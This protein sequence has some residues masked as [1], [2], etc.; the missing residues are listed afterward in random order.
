MFLVKE[1]NVPVHLFN[2]A[3][4]Q[5]AFQTSPDAALV[6]RAADGA[7]LHVNDG[8]CR[9]TG[10]TREEVIGKT[11]LELNLYNHPAD[12][13]QFLSS[14]AKTGV[15][16]SRAANFRRRDGNRFSALVSAKTFFSQ[17]EA[18]VYASLRDLSEQQ[19][20][21]HKKS[22]HEE[23]FRRLFETMSQ[24]VVY[25]DADGRIVS[26]NPAAQ[27]MLGL[28]LAELTQRTS[29]APEWKTIREDGSIL[30]GTEHPSMIALRTGAPYG[31]YTL[32]VYNEKI[33]D[34]VWLSVTATPLFHGEETTPYQAYVVMSDITAQRKAQQN[35][36]QLFQEVMDGFALHEIIIDVAG[37][38]VDYR[39]LAVNPAFERMTGLSGSDLI[40]RTVLEVLPETEQYWIETYGK[41]ALTGEPVTFQNYAASL[42]KYFSV[43]AYRPAPM[44][45]ACTFSDVTGQIRYQQETE[46]AQEQ[47]NRLAHICDVAPSAILVHDDV[48]KILYANEYAYRM[49]GYPKSVFLTLLLSDLCETATS[50]AIVKSAQRARAEGE[51]TNEIVS[52]A[53]D[54]RA[55]P[56]LIYGRPIEWDGE[57]AML[58]I[59]TDI[60]ERQRAEKTLEQSLAQN[61]R[62]LNNLQDG[63]FQAALS[64]TFYMLNPRMAQIYGYDSVAEMMT[65]NT[66]QM[67]ANLEDRAAL[68]DKLQT[69]GQVTSYVCRG[70]RKN[71][72]L[73]WVSMHVQYLRDEA[74]NVIGT[75][76]LIRDITDRRMMEEEIQKQHNSLLAS[77][78]ILKKQLEQSIQAI[79]KIGELR[80]AYTAGHQKRVQQLACQIGARCGLSGERMVNLSYGALI[81]DI[82][83]IY[84]ASDILNKPGKITSLEYQLL[85]THAEFSYN[86]V[87][88]MGLP[89][90]IVTMIH[91]HHERLDGSGYPNHVS[92]DQILLESRIL[93]V[94]DVVEAMTSHRPYRPALGIEAALSEIQAGR[95]TKY[96]AT[97]VDHCVSL[98]RTDGFRFTVDSEARG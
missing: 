91:Q 1:N 3:F 32:A 73:I 83:K 61:R 48:G 37:A 96:D 81:H 70:K 11:T 19:R 5:T 75:E 25:Q 6:T 44:Q 58:T 9:I 53:S 27:A 16:E 30:P 79:S 24:G 95:G 63:F 20:V 60:T 67:Y 90:D 55:I 13:E 17:D 38:P 10:Y 66:K 72:V 33:K 71:G 39:Y 8:F 62:I 41:V 29:L 98:F 18:F 89:E 22:N 57:P 68:L 12:R 82:G 4:F 86:I 40:G 76:G 69:Q 31:P 28:T 92:G 65:A 50:E 74:G 7:I 97:I 45:F 36:Q 35:Y 23:E 21:E 34:Y 56:L 78:E 15:L 26:A 54:G 14:L 85:Q 94:A 80:D 77:N 47:I 46:R 43:T 87:R 2:D 52:K 42:D 51:I 49:H 59:G 88:E 84:V 93:A 64:G